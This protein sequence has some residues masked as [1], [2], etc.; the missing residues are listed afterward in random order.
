MTDVEKPWV[1][2][3]DFELDNDPQMGK[4]HIYVNVYGMVTHGFGEAIHVLG[5]RSGIFLVLK[6]SGQVNIDPDGSSEIPQSI[7]INVC[8]L[9]VWIIFPLYWE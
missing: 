6:D 1:Q 4:V 7:F 8:W 5:F 3:M 9:V 2:P